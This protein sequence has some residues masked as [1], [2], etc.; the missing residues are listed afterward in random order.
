M[1]IEQNSN[2]KFKYVASGTVAAANV[3]ELLVPK[4]SPA[5]PAS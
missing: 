3:P 4:G 2:I 5:N 1:E